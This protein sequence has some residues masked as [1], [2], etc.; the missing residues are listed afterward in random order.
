MDERG[1]SVYK[2]CKRVKDGV[3]SD[4]PLAYIAMLRDFNNWV[5]TFTEEEIVGI[6]AHKVLMED[7]MT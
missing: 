4:Y 6:V 3:E 1:D 2:I 5:E 7:K